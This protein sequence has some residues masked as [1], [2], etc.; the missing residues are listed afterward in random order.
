MKSR[1]VVDPD[2]PGGG[3]GADDHIQSVPLDYML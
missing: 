3:G 1:Q 2:V